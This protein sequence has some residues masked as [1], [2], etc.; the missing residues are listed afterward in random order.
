MYE[1]WR[2]P[3]P[4]DRRALGTWH[5]KPVARLWLAER[6]SR[7]R[8]WLLLN[9]PTRQPTGADTGARGRA[10]RASR[11][12]IVRLPRLIGCLAR[13]GRGGTRWTLLIQLRSVDTVRTPQISSVAAAPNDF[14]AAGRDSRGGGALAKRPI[15]YRPPRGT[16]G[17]SRPRWP[18][19]PLQA[20]S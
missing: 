7:C 11:A 16:V 6:H 17:R 9:T 4:V 19:F 10:G 8:R 18:V 15:I 13:C 3:G 5:Q 1:S 2:S 14:L 20:G 12:I